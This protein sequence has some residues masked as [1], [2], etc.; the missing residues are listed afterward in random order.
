MAL[1]GSISTMLLHEQLVASPT[2]ARPATPSRVV[3]GDS[4]QPSPRVPEAVL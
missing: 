4:V 2:L 3:V 1:V